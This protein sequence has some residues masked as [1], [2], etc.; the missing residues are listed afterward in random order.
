M[1]N[2]ILYAVIQSATEFLPISSSGHLAL[3][4]SVISSPDIFLI[5]ALHLASLAAVL[6]FTRK[7]IKGLLSF[8][9]EQRK[10]WLYLILATIPAA[11]TGLA[12]KE[13][14]EKTFSDMMFLGIAFIFTGIVLFL[15]KYSKEKKGL[16]AKKSLL[17]GFFQSIALF[18]G[19]SRS[20][21][22]IS[23][24]LFS[25]LN[26]ERAAKF[27]FLL[28]IPLAFGAFILEL[29]KFHFNTA[30][31]VSVALCTVLSI[32]CLQLLTKIIIRRK[33][34]MFSFYCFAVGIFVLLN[35][36]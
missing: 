12:L 16:D 35:Y 8:N 1:I 27:S 11:I 33:F 17:I 5:A 23:A 20:G 21:M 28:Y 31:L 29:D 32:F 6:I 2:E 15:T 10:M 34:W 24:G 26:R 25:G 7:E 4:S 19:V 3:A 22:T 13:Q 9:K 18:P 14:I 36:S 30:L